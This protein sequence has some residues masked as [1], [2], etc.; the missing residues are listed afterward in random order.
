MGARRRKSREVEMLQGQSERD[1]DKQIDTWER[2]HPHAAVVKIEKML[3]R[4]LTQQVRY[5][6]KITYERA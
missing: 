6:A 5:E 2:E 3:R 1:L 4:Q